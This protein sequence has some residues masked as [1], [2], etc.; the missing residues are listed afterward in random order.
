MEEAPHYHRS[1]GVLHAC[2]HKCRSALFSWAFW[3]GMTIGFP[4]EH[5]L[6]VKVWP[7]S[8]VTSWM[9]L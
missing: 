2:Y 4:L 3:A 8:A 9:G 7:F 6:W 1:N 5:Y